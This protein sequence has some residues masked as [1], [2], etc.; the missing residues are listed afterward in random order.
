MLSLATHCH[1]YL[2]LYPFHCK[3][4]DLSGVLPAVLRVFIL[5]GYCLATNSLALYIISLMVLCRHMSHL[6]SLVVLLLP[7]VSPKNLIHSFLQKFFCRFMTLTTPN[8]YRAFN[9]QDPLSKHKV[10]WVWSIYG[11]GFLGVS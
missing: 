9:T 5:V 10:E 8:H 2:Q 3:L 1:T 7:G 11:R 4:K 6:L